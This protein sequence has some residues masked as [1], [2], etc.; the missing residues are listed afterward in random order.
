MRD[1]LFRCYLVNSSEDQRGAIG[2]L[3]I[4]IYR[5]YDAHEEE[6]EPYDQEDSR[7]I[8]RAYGR[9]LA[10]LSVDSDGI[11]LDVYRYLLEFVSDLSAIPSMHE[12]LPLI[13][14]TSIERFWMAFDHEKIEPVI[15]PGDQT[16]QV[17]Y[18]MGDISYALRWDIFRLCLGEKQKITCSYDSPLLNMIK[19]AQ[20]PPKPI[21]QALAQGDWPSIVARYMLLCFRPPVFSE[22]PT[23]KYVIGLR[24][25]L[26]EWSIL[27]WFAV[28]SLKQLPALATLVLGFMPISHEVFTDAYPEWLKVMGHLRHL[29]GSLAQGDRSLV[30]LIEAVEVWMRWGNAV[31]FVIF[32]RDSR[33]EIM[34]DYE[35]IVYRTDCNNPRCVGGLSTRA[36]GKCGV[37]RYCSLKCQH[38]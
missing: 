38:E 16:S 30:A 15:P 11:K 19:D 13:A 12:E 35:S 37:A 34:V 23:C 6:S 33:G 32:Q 28:D 26:V 8:I 21:L 1:L 27:L 18:Y 2:L 9:S 31:G 3:F 7:A 24:I 36:C 20:R 4:H 5:L 25:A 14:S 17:M 10:F 29:L 22:F